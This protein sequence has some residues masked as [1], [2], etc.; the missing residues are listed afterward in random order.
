MMGYLEEKPSNPSVNQWLTPLSPWNVFFAKY[1]PTRFLFVVK[2]GCGFSFLITCEE[3]FCF[4]LCPNLMHHFHFKWGGHVNPDVWILTWVR[5]KTP[6]NKTPHVT[7]RGNGFH[8]VN[9]DQTTT[10]RSH[11]GRSTT[12]TLSWFQ[13]CFRVSFKLDKKNAA[14]GKNLIILQTAR[15]H[16]GSQWICDRTRQNYGK[17]SVSKG[18]FLLVWGRGHAGPQ[19]PWMKQLWAPP[20]WVTWRGRGSASGP[21]RGALWLWLQLAAGAAS[22]WRSLTSS[23]RRALVA[24]DTGE[25]RDW[26]ERRWRWSG[27]EKVGAHSTRGLWHQQGVEEEHRGRGKDWG[28]LKV[29]DTDMQSALQVEVAEKSK[30]TSN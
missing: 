29:Q 26:S 25:L 21:R 16:L 9:D 1:F 6:H 7:I 20:A 3:V 19:R 28:G 4:L 2:N 22:P 27:R 11:I 5:L 14:L 8:F 13:P 18:C 23:G 24:G 10:Y 12:R 17:K 30:I 15:F